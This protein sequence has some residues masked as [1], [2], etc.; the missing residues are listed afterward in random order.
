MKHARVYKSGRTELRGGTVGRLTVPRAS[1][2]L[3][4]SNHPRAGGEKMIL[5]GFCAAA[6]AALGVHRG[7]QRGDCVLE[8]ALNTEDAHVSRVGTI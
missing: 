6:A 4:L 2:E 7:A 1:S 3:H 5:L 8:I